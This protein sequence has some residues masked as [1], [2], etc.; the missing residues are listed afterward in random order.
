MGHASPGVVGVVLLIGYVAEVRGGWS[1]LE[2]EAGRLRRGRFWD[3]WDGV[4]GGF[5]GNMAFE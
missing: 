2:R 1:V 4:I 3:L 5:G